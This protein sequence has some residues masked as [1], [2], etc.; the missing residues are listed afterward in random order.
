[1]KCSN[2]YSPLTFTK[3]PAPLI[4]PS[5]SSSAA[6]PTMEA[7]TLP[8]HKNTLCPLFLASRTA[9]LVF[10]VIL[11]DL[12]AKVPSISKN[13]YFPMPF[14]PKSHIIMYFI[15]DNSKPYSNMVP[16]RRQVWLETEKCCEQSRS[17]FP[18]ESSPVSLMDSGSRSLTV[19]TL[20]HYT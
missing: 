2:T 1:M 12:P 5:T 20:C 17:I 6:S 7:G 13:K 8:V 15:P 10:S 3:L 19:Q 18:S 16:G 14:S 11:L 4:M 9:H